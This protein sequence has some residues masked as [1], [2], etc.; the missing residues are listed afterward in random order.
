M[1]EIN[2]KYAQAKLFID[3]GE[4]AMFQQVQ[5]LCNQPFVKNSQI[6]I[7]PDCHAGKGCVIGTTMTIQDQV[8]PS[9]VGVDIG[10][11]VTC[12][13][14]DVKAL[15]FEVLDTFIRHHLPH[16]SS[17]RGKA[18]PNLKQINLQDLR[19]RSAVNLSR[20]E[21]SLGTLG[22]GNHFIEVNRDAEGF[23]YLVIHSGSRS[24]GLHVATYYQD[25]AYTHYEQLRQQTRETLIQE[26]K[27][28][29]QAHLISE[30]LQSLEMEKINRA[31]VPVTGSDLADYLHD[32]DIAQRFAALNRQTMLE[33]ILKALNLQAV[34]VFDTIHNYIDL[35]HQILRKGSI[36]AQLG[37]K[38][39]IPINMR[40]GSIIAVGKGNP[41][42]NYSAPHGAGRLL[43]RSAAKES[44]TL[45]AF[46]DTMKGIYTTSVGANTLDEAPMA[47]KTLD[48]ILGSTTETI[49][50]LEVI[51]PVYNF[52]AS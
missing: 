2:G 28:A 37:E 8:V 7:M 17:V 19:C 30:R 25:L 5:E 51:R 22:G 13:K 21:L 24:L 3:E 23:L 36:S 38:V 18:H 15:D 44:L 39:I 31:L 11:G 1:I 45:E 33:E 41:D 10:C 47:Y 29:G 34:D 35:P 43:S 6:R 26:L 16:G 52:K 50:V 49:D 14:L 48:H 4:S 12:A 42:W 9:L 20:V 27:A 46:Q 40:D 32:M